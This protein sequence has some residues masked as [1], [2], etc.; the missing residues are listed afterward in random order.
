K[1]L[2]H[3]A[4]TVG[5]WLYLG[6]GYL[7]LLA[8]IFTLVLFS[9][10]DARFPALPW[11]GWTL[12]WY[13]DLF[14]DGRLLESLRHSLIVSPL[15]AAAAT[16]IGFFAAYVLNRFD[17]LGKRLLSIVL[18]VPIITPSLILG[19][20]F[21][22]LLSRLHLQGQ[23]FSVFL[24]HVVILIPTAIALITLRLAQMPREMEEAAWNLGAAEWQ[25]LIR[26]VLPWSIPGIAGAWLLAFTFSFDEFVI[27]WFVCGFE[28]TLPVAIYNFLGA[29]LTPS[30]N[31]IGTIFFLI[32]VLLLVGVELLLIPLLLAGK[33]GINAG[34]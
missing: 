20:A 31:A 22:G 30:L 34:E 3:R 29:N 19:V 7:F 25:T 6:L 4:L 18:I 1:S 32:S 8:P 5:G 10:E 23:L 14:A 27:A 28:Q 15:A 26:I 11:A 24:T 13:Q 21:L 16:A 9:F 12:K 2:S 17:F 33:A